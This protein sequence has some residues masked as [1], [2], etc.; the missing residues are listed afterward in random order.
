MKNCG[1]KHPRICAM[2]WATRKCIKMDTNEKCMDGYHLKNTVVYILEKS[3]DI[4]EGQAEVPV[5]QGTNKG[6]NKT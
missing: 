2:S 5:T 1:R 3:R 6:E 4:P